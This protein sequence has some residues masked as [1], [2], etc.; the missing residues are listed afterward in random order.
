[1]RRPSASSK[2]TSISAIKR[3]DLRCRAGRRR[4]VPGSS[5]P[6]R[7]VGGDTR[8]LAEFLEVCED[9]GVDPAQA[10]RADVALFVRVLTS[11]PGR[12]GANVVSIDSGSGLANATSQRLVPVRLFFDY[13]IEEGPRESN[14]VGRGRY[15]PGRRF[16]GQ[17]HGLVPTLTKLPWIPSETEWLALL[18]A[19]RRES[20][21][22]RLMLALAYDAALRPREVVPATTT[23][24]PIVEVTST[25]KVPTRLSRVR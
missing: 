15:T 1:V 9:A 22:S 6:G 5:P 23:L 7:S 21:R 4:T 25:R 24:L 12:R 14:S 17:Q 2:A 13:L 10:S 8:G 18:T 19:F 20:A 3:R 11:R 16:G